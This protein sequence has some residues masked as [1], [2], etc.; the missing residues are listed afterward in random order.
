[1]DF[2]LSNQSDFYNHE[3]YCR[4]YN[5]IPL[6]KIFPWFSS[7]LRIKCKLLP[8]ASKVHHNLAPAYLWLHSRVFIPCPL[9]SNDIDLI[10]EYTKVIPAFIPLHLYLLSKHGL[11]P[12]RYHFRTFSDFPVYNYFV[13]A[14]HFPAVIVPIKMSNETMGGRW[15]T[16]EQQR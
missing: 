2:L 5:I 10:L 1:M 7:I 13:I 4:L 8:R 12:F 14:K 11:I 9:Y 6:L 3:S 16:G 15:G